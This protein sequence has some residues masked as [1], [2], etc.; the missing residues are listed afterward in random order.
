MI[1]KNNAKATPKLTDDQRD[2]LAM[3]D[4]LCR[5]FDDIAKKLGGWDTH[6]GTLLDRQLYELSERLARAADAN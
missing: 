5:E 2:A 1:G 4:Q 6:A 3:Y